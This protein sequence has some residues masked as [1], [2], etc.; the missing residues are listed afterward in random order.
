MEFS[1]L[2]LF[3][4]MFLVRILVIGFRAYSDKPG[5]FCLKIFNLII[6]A[7]ILFHGLCELNMG[8]SFGATI[9][10]TISSNLTNLP[11]VISSLVIIHLSQVNLPAGHSPS[12]SAPVD[13]K[14]RKIRL[15][16]TRF[17]TAEHVVGRLTSSV[18]QCLRS[19]NAL[20]KFLIFLANWLKE[21][22]GV[23]L[24]SKEDGSWRME[25]VLKSERNREKKT[26]GIPVL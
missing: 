9:Q 14:A 22:W 18:G 15:W 11:V 8:I 6:S 19:N 21:A 23:K 24:R 25:R 13:N 17:G 26:Q 4:C 2:C 5:W 20:P 3:L 1:Y 16:A 12:R 7:K 10:P